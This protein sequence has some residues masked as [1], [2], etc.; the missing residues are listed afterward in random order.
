MTSGQL[1]ARLLVASS[2]ATGACSSPS[3]TSG[4]GAASTVQL[5]TGP[6]ASASV[7]ALPSSRATAARERRPLKPLTPTIPPGWHAVRP[8]EP[9]LTANQVPVRLLSTEAKPGDRAFEVCS[10][11]HYKWAEGRTGGPYFSSYCYERAAADPC[12]GATEPPLRRAL[13]LRGEADCVSDGPYEQLSA[14]SDAPLCCYNTGWFGE[15]R[16]LLVAGDLRHA[17][18]ACGPGWS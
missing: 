18:L 5:A 12:L 13:S 10:E 17:S 1:L 6:R 16:P 3:G 15:G 7:A 11:S 14:E 9:P 4:Q 8:P 2:A